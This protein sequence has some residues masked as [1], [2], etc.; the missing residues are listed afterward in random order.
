MVIGKS[1]SFDGDVIDQHGALDYWLIKININGELEWSK[2]YGSSMS[3]IPYQIIKTLDEGFV[4]AGYSKGYDG[5]VTDNWGNADY[6]IIK[7]N[8]VG[9][10]IWQKTFGGPDTDIAHSIVEKETSGFLCAGE[11]YSDGGMVTASNGLIDNWVIS[12]DSIGNLEWERSYGGPQADNGF[13]I[14][15]KNTNEYTFSGASQAIGGDVMENNGLS[16]YWLVGIDTLGTILYQK[17]VGGTNYDIPY[18][19]VNTSDGYFVITGMSYSTDL[20]VTESYTGYNYW[21]VKLGICNTL[22]YADLDEDGF[23][24][25]LNDSLTCELPLGYVL[26]STDCNDANNLVYPGA[27][28]ICNS[29]DDNCN[30]F[31]DEDAIFVLYFADTDSDG[32]GTLLQDSVSCNFPAGYVI[33]STDCNDTNNLIYPEA[34]DICNSIDD[35]CNGIIDEDAV[36]T[37]YYADVDGDGYGNGLVDSSSCFTPLGFVLNSTDCNDTS[38][39]IYPGAIEICDYLDNDCNGIIDDNLSY[40]QSFEDADGDNYGNIFVDSLS[41]DIPDGFVLNDSDC[42]DTDPNIYDD[43]CNDLIDEGLYLEN[44]SIDGIKIYPNPTQ[45]LLYI[46]WSNPTPTSLQLININGQVIFSIET[47]LPRNIIDV[48]NYPSGIYL[49]KSINSDFGTK[50]IKE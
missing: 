36:F 15:K 6:W 35:N 50:F 5:D 10:L 26:D 8:S 46:E 24:D 47:V 43:D 42:D 14:V 48:G 3:D 4:I 11:S 18:V 30:G 17:S 27:T 2:S 23:G 44:I 45:G 22:Y 37:I 19:M 41:C 29:L 7:I 28:D 13:S 20:D 32:F 39:L 33:D 16:D 38:N 1:Q 21:I 9:E 34:T 40:I 12:L 49:I 25:I 31:I